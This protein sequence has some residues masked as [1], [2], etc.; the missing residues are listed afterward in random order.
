VLAHLHRLCDVTDALALKEAKLPED[1]GD[2]GDQE[3]AGHNGR[4]HDPDG[5]TG[6]PSLAC[7]QRAFQA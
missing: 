4:H 2:N 1:E 6:Q 5:D 3:E 7:K